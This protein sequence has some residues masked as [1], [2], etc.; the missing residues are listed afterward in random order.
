MVRKQPFKYLKGDGWHIVEEGFHPDR[1]RVSESLFS[2]SNEFMG[3]RGYFEE[4]YSGDHLQG[5]YFGGLYETK[6]IGHPQVFKGFVTHEHYIVNAVDWLYTRIRVDE[7]TLDL[8]KVVFSEF[9]RTSDM[10]NG[11]GS[12]SFIWETASGKKL[13]CTFERF[14]SMVDPNLGCQR[15]VF[16]PLNFSGTITIRSGLNFGTIQEIDAGWDMTVLEGARK[17]AKSENNA[18]TIH[19]KHHDKSLYAIQA[20]TKSTD[21]SCFSSFRLCASTDISPHP[22]EDDYRIGCE[23]TL[24]ATQGR[25]CWFDKIAVNHWERPWEQSAEQ[26]WQTGMDMAAHRS[27]VTYDDARAQHKQYWARK[28]ENWDILLEGEPDLQQGVRFDLFQF[29]MAYHAGDERLAIPSKGLTAEVYSG[30]VFWVLESYCQHVMIFTDPEASRKLFRFRYR[31]LQNAIERAAQLDCEGA[32]YPFCTIDGPESCATWQHAD[33]EIHVGEAIFMALQRYVQH[34]KDYAFLYSEGI[35]MLLQ[36][37]RYY[38]SRGDW[39]PQGQF[40]FYGVMGPDEYKTLVHHNYYINYMAKKC[41][42]YTVETV[43]HMKE[44]APDALARVREKVHLTDE[45]C[46]LWKEMA[47]NMLLLHDPDTGL[48]EQNEGFFNL[49]EVDVRAIGEDQIPLYNNWAYERILRSRMVKQADVL[50][51]PVWY[52]HEWRQ[53]AKKVNYDYYE[54]ITIHESSFSPSIHQILAAELGYMDEAQEFF[55]LMARLDLDD[56]NKNTAQGLHMTPKS[57]TWMCMTY[58]FAGMRTDTDPITFAPSIPSSWTR[59]RFRIVYHGSI[60]QVTVTPQQAHFVVVQGNAVTIAVYGESRTV[61]PDGVE[62]PL[63]QA[64]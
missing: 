59:Y 5:S 30:W 57:G 13:R 53:S 14:L 54:P 17:S 49:P 39:T 31:G 11:I 8:A 43:E 41:F 64:S 20:T 52:A 33:M 22:I 61:G 58:G 3:V 28:W 55:R 21:F 46:I 6:K 27:G 63:S 50:L 2:L 24:P 36:I 45:E 35:E 25:E 44:E 4:G 62:I 42:T 19:A 23:F 9:T 34:V 60:L 56:Y 38:A 18:W 40:G 32:K 47:D 37:C 16:E 29:H 12:R 1:Q 48:C 15:V 26:V 10:K 51:L 7:E